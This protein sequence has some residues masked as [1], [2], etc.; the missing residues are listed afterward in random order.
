MKEAAQQSNPHAKFGLYSGPPSAYTRQAYGVDW[1]M[2]AKVID[3]AMSEHIPRNSE[4]IARSY[5]AA[6]QSSGHRVPLL[7]SVTINGYGMGSQIQAWRRRPGLQNQLLQ[8]II[9]WD[10]MS[11][12][13]T[14]VWGFDSQF[15]A[16][17]RKAS[18]VFADHENILLHGK[19][20][21]NL[22]SIK[23]KN[24]EYAAW[25][26]A[27][28]TFIVAFFFNNS[29]DVKQV[30]VLNTKAFS[31][32]ITKTEVDKRN[33]SIHFSIPSWDCKVIKFIK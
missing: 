4:F 12:A 8:T 19:H 28:K 9:D 1:E 11:L 27:D 26:A 5:Y 18:A 13:L 7:M 20:D 31:Q 33:N 15:N 22:L 2:A 30:S 29:D 21:D 32:I 16:P 23:P 17:I 10:A 6:M 3:I 14:G 25:L 24:I